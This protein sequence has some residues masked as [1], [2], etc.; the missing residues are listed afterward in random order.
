MRVASEVGLAAVGVMQSLKGT[1]SILELLTVVANLP[2][3]NK[4]TSPSGVE[5]AKL[6]KFCCLKQAGSSCSS[7]RVGYSILGFLADQKVAG[8]PG[9]ALDGV[10]RAPINKRYAVCG[11]IHSS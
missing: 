5:A 10:F 4:A 6:G 7:G 3:P 1:C 8:A 9:A 2:Y 11:E